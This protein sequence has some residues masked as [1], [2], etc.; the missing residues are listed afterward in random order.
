M[1]APTLFD[2]EA[3]AATTAAGPRPL[4]IGLD[5]SLTSTGIAGEGWTDH[6]RT[7]RIGDARLAYLEEGIASF[8]RNADMVVMEGPSFGHAHLG[9]HEDMAGLRVLVRRYCFRHQ[10]PYGVVPPSSLKLY[11]AGYGKASKGEVRSAVADRY[12]VHTEGGA[13]Y[14]EADAYAALAA[15]CDWWGAPLA[16]VPDRQRK[17]LDGCQWPDREA[18]TTR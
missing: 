13:R 14:D 5:L 7:K 1:S 11:V 4:I 18:V 16:V 2:T 6:I 9:G 8:I 10:I 3:P 15:A 17:A 12:G